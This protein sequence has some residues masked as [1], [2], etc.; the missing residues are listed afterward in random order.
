MPCRI[1][2]P[3]HALRG[4]RLHLENMGDGMDGPQVTAIAGDRLP[5]PAFSFGVFAAFLERVGVHALHVAV[6]GYLLVPF[7]QG[8]F[9][10]RAHHLTA[11]GIER[12]RVMQLDGQQVVGMIGD[13]RFPRRAC[14]QDIAGSPGRQ[15]LHV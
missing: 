15:R 12:D 11:A 8:A 1:G 7:A 2:Q 3:R 4:S 14:L 13:D 10:H 6:S 9:E 5:P